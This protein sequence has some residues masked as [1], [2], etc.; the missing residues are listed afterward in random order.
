VSIIKSFA[1]QQRRSRAKSLTQSLEVDL[2][3]VANKK[4]LKRITVKLL[5]TH[6]DDVKQDL[7]ASFADSMESP[8]GPSVDPVDSA[9]LDSSVKKRFRKSDSMVPLGRAIALSQPDLHELQAIQEEI[10]SRPE[11]GDNERRK[12]M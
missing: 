5:E 11:N 6:P 4:A 12:S 2:K 7:R 10:R 9:G 3:D 8:R 1:E